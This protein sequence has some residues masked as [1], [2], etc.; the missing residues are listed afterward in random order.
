MNEACNFKKN[1]KNIKFEK[2]IPTVNLTASLL[3]GFPDK[4]SGDINMRDYPILYNEM[5]NI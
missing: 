1:E 3:K 2:L 4:I 5:C